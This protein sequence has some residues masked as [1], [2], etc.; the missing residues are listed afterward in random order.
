[1]AI[2][3]GL[4]IPNQYL[5]EIDKSDL[6]W[7]TMKSRKKKTTTNLKKCE[8]IRTVSVGCHNL[9]ILWK[10]SYSVHLP[11]EHKKFQEFIPKKIEPDY[12]EV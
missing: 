12:K 4:H 9:A 1:M 8:Y 3:L 2:R 6:S 10:L 5:L 7:Y 11:S